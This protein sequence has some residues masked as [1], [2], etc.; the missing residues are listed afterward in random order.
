MKRMSTIIFAISCIL[1]VLGFVAITCLVS[2]FCYGTVKAESLQNKP[3]ATVVTVQR[4]LIQYNSTYRPPLPNRGDAGR[5]HSNVN[6]NVNT[7]V[8][9][10]TIGDLNVLQYKEFTAQEIESVLKYQLKGLGQ[11]FHDTAKK[12]DVNP[13]FLVSI[14]GLESGWGRHMLKRNNIAGVLNCSFK[15]KNSC[16]EY[17]AKLLATKYSEGGPCHHG[18]NTI[19]DISLN[20]CPDGGHWNSLITSIMLDLYKQIYL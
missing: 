13:L 10:D 4:N 16:I 6:A 17:L 12:Y 2:Y 18:E 1:L 9:H 14:C 3:I 15:S 8:T 5:M 11:A 19:S 7:T 20:Y